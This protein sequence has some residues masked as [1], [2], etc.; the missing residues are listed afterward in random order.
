MA[1]YRIGLFALTLAATVACSSGGEG[2]LHRNDESN[3]AAD[4][5]GGVDDLSTDGVVTN[6]TS[7][8][9]VAR[10]AGDDPIGDAR[11]ND[12]PAGDTSEDPGDD[13]SDAGEDE[14]DMDEL[15]VREFFADSDEDGF[16]DPAVSVTA[17]EAPEDYVDNDE[18]CDDGNLLRA[19]DRNEVCDLVDNDC[20]EQ[21][22]DGIPTD[23]AGCVD[24]GSPERSDTI[25]TV[26][27]AIR[28]GF[29]VNDGA[30]DNTLVACLS[31]DDCFPL[32]LPDVDDRRVGEIDVYHFY[33]LDLPRADVD[34]LEL[35]S[36][37]GED[38]WRPVCV[39][40]QLDG[41][42]TYCRDDLVVGLSSQVGEGSKTFTDRDLSQR[43]E[44]CYL[45][46]L[47]HGPM[48]GAVQDD[49]VRI[50]LRTDATRR[51]GVRIDSDPDLGDVEPTV[52]LYPNPDDD[53]TAIADIVGLNPET[54]YFYDVM[55]DGE[56][57]SDGSRVYSFETPPSP[58]DPTQFTFAF[59][60]CTRDAEQPIFAAVSA[61]RPELFLFVGDNHYG[62]TDEIEALRHNYRWSRERPGRGE[63]AELQAST[64][65]LAVWDDHD[66]VGNN[67]DGTALGKGVALQAFEEFWAN[68]SYGTEEVP[69][70][71]SVVRYGDVDFFL[72]D[73]RYYRDLDDSILGDSQT[74]WLETAL[75][76]STATFKFLV[77]GSQFNPVGSGDSWAVYPTASDALFDTIRDQSISGVVMLSGDVHFSEFRTIPRG[78]DGGYDFPELTSSPMANSNSTCWSDDNSNVCLD[79]GNYFVS[80]EVDTAAARPYL[81]AAIRN[82]A[83]FERAEWTVYADELVVE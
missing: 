49:S 28:T 76:S 21:V 67:T 3:D 22:D 5:S 13:A 51:V 9:D 2:V 72:L 11:D 70:I 42:P 7:G 39:E 62:N 40:M 17:C 75:T 57:R 78:H 50:W 48:V 6:D 25:S 23:G 83:G 15:C 37:A 52:W 64:S 33:D 45:S 59:G 29:G 65:V 19:P 44:T 8:G 10:D 56:T 34:R 55:V 77:S 63:R 68:P 14:A 80:V 38:L 12:A 82:V 26:S 73:D 41:E 58:G 18:D 69:G 79:N 36:T 27:L 43:C 16:G 1:N 31:A 71:F 60:S 35:R 74:S 66:F 46:M 53:Y 4:V 47:T 20:D 54:T 81:R 61:L 24:P 32:N 30:D